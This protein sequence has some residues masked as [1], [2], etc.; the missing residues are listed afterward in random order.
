MATVTP[1]L[2]VAVTFTAFL[3]ELFRKAAPFAN[4]NAVPSAV[5]AVDAVKVVP[6]RVP[7]VSVTLALPEESATIVA[8]PV[9]SDITVPAAQALKL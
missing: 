3:F 5:P 9:G 8:A 1:A 4:E 7:I 2:A 6:E